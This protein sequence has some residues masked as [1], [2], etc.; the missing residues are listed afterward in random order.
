MS[1]IIIRHGIIKPL[2]QIEPN[3]APVSEDILARLLNE[4]AE[5]LAA[6]LKP[7]FVKIIRE[8]G[9]YKDCKNANFSPIFNVAKARSILL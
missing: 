8:G 3:K 6:F 2:R 4:V 5:I 1:K 9:A 7:I